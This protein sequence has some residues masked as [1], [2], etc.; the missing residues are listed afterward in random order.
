MNQSPVP[1]PTQ[2]APPPPPVD[3]RLPGGLVVASMGKRIGAY[4]LDGIILA[5]AGFVVVAI[6][7]SVG[8]WISRVPD[9]TRPLDI[10]YNYPAL[11]IDMVVGLAISGTYFIYLWTTRRATLGQG[12][13][14][15]QLGEA[16]SGATLPMDAA[17]KRWIALGAPISLLQVLAPL[18]AI[19]YVATLVGLIWFIALLV[20][21]WNDPLHRGIHDKYAGSM[22]VATA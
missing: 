20:T 15:I 5:I 6:L 14:G 3:P 22:V 1:Q 16:A 9:A 12:A 11:L 2:W 7:S 13:L 10:E 21:T 19:Y 4:I 17:I 18:G 8:L